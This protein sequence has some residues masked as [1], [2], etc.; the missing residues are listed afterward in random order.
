MI[1][2]LI[3]SQAPLLRKPESP[4]TPTYRAPHPTQDQHAPQLCTH[5]QIVACLRALLSP[6]GGALGVLDVAGSD[7]SFIK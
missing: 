2:Y 3:R 5:A 4:T 6:H 1:R 7:I